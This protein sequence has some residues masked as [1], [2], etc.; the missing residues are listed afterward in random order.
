M[1]PEGLNMKKCTHENIY[2]ETE[3]ESKKSIIHHGKPT[4]D[5]RDVTFA[6][7][8]LT[9]GKCQ[10]R[11]YYSG[12]ENRL[13][14]TSSA[15]SKHQNEIHFVSMDLLNEYETSLFG[16]SQQGKSID[17]FIENKNALNENE[18]DEKRDISLKQFYK[19][20][21]I[22]IHA[23]KYDTND[24]FGCSKCPKELEGGEKEKTLKILKH[25]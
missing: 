18:R 8:Y 10:C 5:S 1:V 9:T 15:P 17:A 21:E 16:K 25:T 2:N 20:F 3:L 6:V 23:T 4:Q 19:A 13:I 22:Y 14:R 12:T 24:A 11:I 7:Y